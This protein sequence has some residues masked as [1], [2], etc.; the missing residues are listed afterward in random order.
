M[1]YLEQKEFYGLKRV[2]DCDTLWAYLY[3]NNQLDIHTDASDHQLGAAIRQDDKPIAF[4]S[5]KRT[6]AQTQ[7]TLT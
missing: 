4:Y 5:R 2:V 1:I 7:Y 3:F 6:E